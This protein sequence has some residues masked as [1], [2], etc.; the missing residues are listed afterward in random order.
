LEPRAV[1]DFLREAAELSFMIM[2]VVH[3]SLYCNISSN[4]TRCG[5]ELQ[6]RRFVEERCG[7]AWVERK[8][9]AASLTKRR[10]S[11]KEREEVASVNAKE[12]SRL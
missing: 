10:R 5:A 9:N 11:R 4:L 1:A 3:E 6:W 12:F 7:G 8:G 2:S